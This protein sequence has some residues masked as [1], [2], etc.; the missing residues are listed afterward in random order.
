MN[1]QRHTQGQRQGQNHEASWT[2]I[3]TWIRAHNWYT[4]TQ[5]GTHIHTWITAHTNAY[6]Q[7]GTHPMDTEEDT[8]IVTHG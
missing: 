5:I 2:R 6:I 8:H 7:I 1:R 3:H 4:F